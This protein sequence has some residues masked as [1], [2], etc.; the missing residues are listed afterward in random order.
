MPLQGKS[1]TVLHSGVRVH[2]LKQ[3]GG[4][5]EVRDLIFHQLRKCPSVTEAKA[6][7][8][9]EDLSAAVARYRAQDGDPV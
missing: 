2:L 9:D 8:R 4:S 1:E 7:P 6:L 3:L 5:H